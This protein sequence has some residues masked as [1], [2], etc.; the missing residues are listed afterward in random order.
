MGRY[1]DL[2]TDLCLGRL[3]PGGGVVIA[4][5]RDVPEGGTPKAV[6]PTA[7]GTADHPAGIRP[8]YGLPNP[9][10]VR[11]L[12]KEPRH[13]SRSQ[14]RGEGQ[15]ERCAR[16]VRRDHALGD[17]GGDNTAGLAVAGAHDGVKLPPQQGAAI[18]QGV[19]HRRR[20][21]R[22]ATEA[23]FLLGAVLDAPA[24]PVRLHQSLHRRPLIDA[25]AEEKG[26]EVGEG[27][28]TQ[29]SP[30]VEIVTSGL[31]AGDKVPLVS[32]D[33]AG[34]PACHRPDGTCIERIQQDRMRYQ[35]VD[36]P[37]AVDEW[38][39]PQQAMMGIGRGEAL[40]VVLKTASRTAA[41]DALA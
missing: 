28:L 8:G 27:L 14:S 1:T 26:G 4:P 30:P 24:Q 36:P 3:E 11:L 19:E 13:P 2:W 12:R 34:E 10:I 38:M 15:L 7:Q 32:R 23:G 17:Q 29:V 41:A 18:E 20:L 31:V 35:G 33:L 40:I 37:V 16:A 6:P 5:V 21:G 25:N 9:R 39:Y 22:Q